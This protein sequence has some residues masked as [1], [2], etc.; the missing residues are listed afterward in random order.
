MQGV[1]RG[2]VLDILHR[3]F[4]MRRYRRYRTYPRDPHW[5]TA[6]FPGT[7]S[8][9]GCVNAIKAGDYVFHYP[10]GNTTYCSTCSGDVSRRASAEL[11]DEDFFAR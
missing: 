8:T 9:K 4:P 11:A 10:N 7:C 1:D 5:I 2:T 6:R 3:E